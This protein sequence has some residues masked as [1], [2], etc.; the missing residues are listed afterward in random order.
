M[1]SLMQTQYELFVEGANNTR[2]FL[3]AARRKK[4]TVNSEYE[5]SRFRFNGNT[6]VSSH[7]GYGLDGISKSKSAIVGSVK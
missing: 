3:L 1:G 7:N 4:N 2:T 5:I 6:N